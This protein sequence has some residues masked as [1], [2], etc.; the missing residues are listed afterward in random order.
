M[1]SSASNRICRNNYFFFID[2]RILARFI[3]SIF[4]LIIYQFLSYVEVIIDG[5]TI[6]I[7]ELIL[8]DSHGGFI[9]GFGWAIL[10]LMATVVGELFEN[11]DMIKI[12]ILGI[13]FSTVGIVLS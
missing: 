8:N 2:L 10:M 12:F 1:G 7:S 3:I 11:K 4:L 9:G 5:N 13:L 6:V